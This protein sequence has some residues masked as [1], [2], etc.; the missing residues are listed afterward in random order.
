V[1]FCLNYL[2]PDLDVKLAIMFVGGGLGYADAI[3]LLATTLS[4]LKYML[5][6]CHQFVDT[7]CVV[8]NSSKSKPLFFGRSDSRSYV[9]VPHVEFNGSV[10]E[11]VQHARR[12]RQRHRTKLL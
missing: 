1:N 4:S 11:V 8:F 7:Y 2:P 3:T 12:A 9:H 6:I 5:N 10:I